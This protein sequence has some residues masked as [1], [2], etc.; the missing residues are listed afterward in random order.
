MTPDPFTEP[1]DPGQSTVDGGT[2]LLDLVAAVDH[3]RRGLRPGLTI[4]DALEEALRAGEPDWD[5]PEP[6]RT[7]LAN[8]LDRTSG[9]IDL[10]LQ[11]AVR[12]WVLVA[13]DRYNAGHH[14]PHPASRR[15]F[16]PP[17]LDV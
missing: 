1:G 14:W 2:W 17:A 13:A 4:W 3:L 8:L 16:P 11:D 12:S 9:P 5:D 10:Q 6:L 15:S 7:A